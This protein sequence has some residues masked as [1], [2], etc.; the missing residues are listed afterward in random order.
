MAWDGFG[1]GVGD[2]GNGPKGDILGQAS[3]VIRTD[4]CLDLPA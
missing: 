1:G 2:T 3:A 4:H